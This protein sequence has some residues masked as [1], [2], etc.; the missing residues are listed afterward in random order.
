MPFPETVEE[1]D[2]WESVVADSQDSR[3]GAADDPDSLERDEV[4]AQMLDTLAAEEPSILPSQ[5][6][7][8]GLVTARRGLGRCQLTDAERARLFDT[9]VR[10][11]LEDL[12]RVRTQLVS[13]TFALA[14]EAASRGLHTEVG[15]SLVDWLGVR[16]PFTPRT[17]A[18]QIAAVVAVAGTAWGAPLVDAL[19]TGAA[20]LHRVAR[21]ARTMSRLASSLEPDRQEVYAR[22]AAGAATDRRLSDEQVGTV[23]RKLVEDLLEEKEPGEAERAAHA[24]RSVS[25]RIVGEGLTRFTIDAP[26]D[27]TVTLRGIFASRLSAPVPTDEGPD[28][29]SAGQRRFDALETVINRGLSDPGAAPSSARAAIILTLPFDAAT[30]TPAGPGWTPT[31][32]HLSRRQAGQLACSAE[33]TPVWL[34]AQGEPLRLGRTARLASPG[35]WKAL[36]VRDRHCT[37]PGCTVPPQ[38]C[39]SHHLTSWS[40]GG[41]TDLDTLAL[42]CQRHHTQVHQDDIVATIVGGVLTWHV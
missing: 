7:D 40:R 25:S 9:S 36:V 1:R 24:L 31:G 8:A 23:C 2:F 19:A 33:I 10:D 16:C 22:I 38:W 35:Q 32:E 27:L 28:P 29:R 14:L 18:A 21:V 5:E 26:D 34:S 17:D 30:G 6:V 20:P 3:L 15:L 4:L 37:Y 11:S 42:L 13:V 39:D 12:D 41:S